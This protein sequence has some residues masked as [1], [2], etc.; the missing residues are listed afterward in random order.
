MDSIALWVVDQRCYFICAIDIYTKYAWCKLVG[1]LSSRQAKLAL[2]EFKGKFPYEIKAIQTD[3]GSEFLGEFEKYLEEQGI[4]HNFI[5]PR[6]PKINS[7][8]ERFNRTI[9][10]E[11]IQRN[12]HLGIDTEKFNTDLLKYL[13]WYNQKRPH[14]TLGLVSPQSFINNLKMEA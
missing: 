11:F 13:S 7:I 12:D 1:N 4:P 2:M 9:Q 5:Y 3:N 6:S 14:H 10:E 8:V